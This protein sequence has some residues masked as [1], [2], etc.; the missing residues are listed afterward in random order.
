MTLKVAVALV[1]VES[2]ETDDGLT[3]QPTCA[4]E[5]E[6]VHERLT[7]PLNPPVPVAVIVEVPFGQSV[8]PWTHGTLLS[9]VV[10]S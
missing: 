8:E 7:V 10:M 6:I 3:M 5:E 1:V 2:S 9:P 4:V